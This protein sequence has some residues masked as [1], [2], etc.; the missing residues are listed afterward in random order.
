MNANSIRNPKRALPEIGK[1]PG[2]AAPHLAY[3]SQLR[4]MTSQLLRTKE[5]DRVKLSRLLHD[6]I[7]QYLS[8]AGLQ[9]DILRMDLQ[10]RLPDIGSRASEIQELIAEIVQRIRDLSYELDPGIVER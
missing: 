10:D 6:E 1:Q 3:S 4:A 7:G 5:L 9:L 2:G 8:S